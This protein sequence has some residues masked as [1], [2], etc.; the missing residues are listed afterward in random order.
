MVISV[1]IYRYLAPRGRGA[2][3]FEIKATGPYTAKRSVNLG[4]H[5]RLPFTQLAQ[6]TEAF[7]MPTEAALETP[8]N[9]RGILSRKM[10][11]ASTEA[12]SSCSAPTKPISLEKH[13]IPTGPPALLVSLIGMDGQAN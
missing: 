3:V 12:R 13:I 1:A 8:M 5:G 11:M 9:C 7:V 6:L 4:D 10:T 2:Q